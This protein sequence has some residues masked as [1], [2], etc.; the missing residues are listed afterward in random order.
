MINAAIPAHFEPSDTLLSLLNHRSQQPTSHPAFTFLADGEATATHLSYKELDQRAK[1]I[2]AVLQAQQAAGER[3]LLLYHPGLEYIAAFFGCLYA[4][5]VA[6]PAYPPHP[7]RPMP[8][9]KAILEDASATIALT[10]S[11][12]LETLQ[13]RDDDQLK[14]LTLIAT[15]TISTEHAATWQQPAITGNTLAFLQYTSGSTSTPKGVKITHHNLLYTIY[16]LYAGW[17]HTEESVMVTWMPIFHD[18]G[19]IYGILTPIYGH[20]HCVLMA[21]A[22]FIQKP[23]RWLQAITDYKGTHT[24]A[25]NF[26]Y[27]LCLR[28]VTAEQLE[29]IDLSSLQ[30]ALN[31]A[32]PIRVETLQNFTNMY[33]P[34][35]F[36][37]EAF[38]AGYGL[39]E[40]SVKV[41]AERVH[42][43]TV[44]RSLDAAALEQNQLVLTSN[45]DKAH[46]IVGCGRSEIGADIRIVNPQTLAQ[47][48][49]DEVGEIWVS[50]L[51]IAQGYWNRPQATQETFH[52]YTAD[53][54]EGPFMR[55]GDLGFYEAQEKELYITGRLKDLLIIRGRNHYPH[56][57]ELTV[58]RA[59]A[60]LRPGCGAAFSLTI[61]GEEKLA[62]VQ[63]LNRTFVRDFDEE[64]IFTAIREAVS[65]EHELQIQ[66][67]ALLR[68]GQLLKTSS[69]KIQRQGNKQAFLN[70]EL[71]ELARWEMA[72]ESESTP[73]PSPELNGHSPTA[74]Q[75]QQWM[76][77]WLHRHLGLPLHAIDPQQPFAAY[78]LDSVAAVELAQE[79]EDWLDNQVEVEVTIVWNYPTLPEL[80]HHLAD[81]LAQQTAS[82]ETNDF[83]SNLD[84]LSEEKLV[85]LLAAELA[86]P[87]GQNT[88]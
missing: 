62:V 22:T 48:A 2:A 79:L 65:T 76:Q 12:I 73:L 80:A 18:L 13:R 55:T 32:E 42:H 14:T 45:S 72:P 61:D 58:E 35:G 15:D 24:H 23:A 57:I 67:I 70:D 59:H 51:S 30:M 64:E 20:Y 1:A 11:D 52:A 28:K 8:R 41:S 33:Q 4:G 46:L 21:P 69:G 77:Q 87:K 29:T 38:C 74:A 60:A 53:T 75:I 63:E 19:L 71:V 84:D 82:Q 31:A 47:C 86:V 83:H 43:S 17:N 85:A 39:A 9:L 68:T 34:Y 25:P 10:T 54:N 36:R 27:E 6:V 78:G 66:A 49:A 37:Y 3:A 81:Q 26:A 40:A 44:Y 56:D 5:V 50:S 7:K 16:D 88:Q